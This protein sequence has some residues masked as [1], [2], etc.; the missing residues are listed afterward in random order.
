[1]TG[2][3]LTSI[4]RKYLSEYGLEEI[5]EGG[6]T[7][8][9]FKKGDFLCEQGAQLECLMLIVSGRVKVYSTAANGKTLLFC[10]DDPGKI[11]GEVE[12]MTNAFATSSVSAISDVRCIVIPHDRYRDYLMSNL[13]FMSRIGATMAEIIMETAT[14]GASNILYPF[15]TRL[16]A[17]ICS[18]HENGLFNR[19]LTELAEYLGTSYRHLLRTLDNLCTRGILEKTARGYII[20]DEQTLR[21]IGN[22]FFLR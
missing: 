20:R 5:E 13:K 12:L 6:L 22:N 14:N 16:C 3:I 4:D 11:I 21:T 2:G 9:A 1:M 7:M 18:A 15:E 19:K 10:V 17:Y 8:K